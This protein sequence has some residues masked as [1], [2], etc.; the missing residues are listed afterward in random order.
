MKY[1]VTILLMWL[2]ALQ[3][4]SKMLIIMGYRW[5]KDYISKTLCVNRA[6]PKSCCR[7]KCFLNKKLVQD[8]NPASATGNISQKDFPEFQYLSNLSASPAPEIAALAQSHFA[9]FVAGKSQDFY[10]SFLKP[11]QAMFC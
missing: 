8:E 9:I 2:I 7:G 3:T 4:F 1:L 10:R 11:P 5:N 6:N